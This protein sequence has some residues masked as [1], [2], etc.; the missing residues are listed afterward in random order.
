MKKEYSNFYPF[1]KP[2][3]IGAA[4]II[5]PEA[6]YQALKCLDKEQALEIANEPSPVRTKI[7]GSLVK[8]RPDWEPGYSGFKYDAMGLMLTYKFKEG[9]KLG[10]ILRNDPNGYI[11]EDNRHH[12]NIWGSCICEKCFHTH[13]LNLLGTLL[14]EIRDNTYKPKF[15]ALEAAEEL[16]C[17]F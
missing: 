7:L 16:F 9:T 6:G 4:T 2:L 14:M 5:T 8:L 1:E 3:I 11:I 12:D 17:G 13:G 10:D 15:D